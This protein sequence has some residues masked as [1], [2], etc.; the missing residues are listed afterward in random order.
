MNDILRLRIAIQTIKDYWKTTLIVSLLFVAMAAMYTGM[1][2]SFKDLLAEMMQSGSS[3]AYSFLPHA[4]QMH[5]YVGFLTIELYEIFWLLILAIIIGFIAASSITKEIEGKTID[6]LMSN[7]VSR[8][9]IVIEK[10]IGLIPM[11][12]FVNFA[13]MLVVVGITVLLNEDLNFGYLFLVHIVSILYFLAIISIGILI[14][15]IFDEK[16]RASIIMIAVLVGMYII[17]SLSLMSPDFE[18]MG[19]L[20]IYQYFD[21]FEVL[22]FGEINGAGIFA[23]IGIITACLLISMIYFEHKDIPI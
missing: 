2:P 8:K 20:S 18:F 3:D 7:P 17:N 13:T 4:D 22:K 19:S 12:L 1:Y 6:L 21:T 5:T 9:Q 15:V 23:Y 14:S 11:F 16:M 10:F